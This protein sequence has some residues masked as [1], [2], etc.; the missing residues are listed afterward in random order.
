M[1][2]SDVKE[3]DCGIGGMP[4]ADELYM[5]SSSHSAAVNYAVELY[6]QLLLIRQRDWEPGRF[7][8]WIRGARGRDLACYCPLDQPCHGDKLLETANPR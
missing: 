1:S 7:E 5:S 8:K 3:W 2:W 6:G 4:N